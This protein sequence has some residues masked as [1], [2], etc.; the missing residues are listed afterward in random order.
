ATSYTPRDII[1]SLPKDIY[2]SWQLTSNAKSLMADMQATSRRWA[3]L[4]TEREEAM[5]HAASLKNSSPISYGVSR[6]PLMQ[7]AAPVYRSEP[8]K[9]QSL[10]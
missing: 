1:V 3:E 2:A 8:E 4:N 10:S 7:W 9:I 6:I 5:G